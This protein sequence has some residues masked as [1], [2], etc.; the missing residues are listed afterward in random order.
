VNSTA[1]QLQKASRAATQLT[2]VEHR[3]KDLRLFKGWQQLMIIRRS[4][5]EFLSCDLFV[6]CMSNHHLSI[7]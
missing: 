5:Q 7:A 4:V 3:F 2:A 1:P 6:R